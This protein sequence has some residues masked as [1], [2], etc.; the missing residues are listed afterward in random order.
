MGKAEQPGLAGVRA[1]L[2]RAHIQLDELDLQ[3]EA[4]GDREPYGTSDAQPN[5]DRRQWVWYL[6]FRPQMPLTWG[7]MLGEIVHDLRSALD[8][9]IFQLTLN[10]VH[11]EISGTGFPIS[12][13]PTSWDKRGGKR[14]A[15]NPLAYD[16]RCAMYQLRGVG[17]GVVEYIKRLQPYSTQDPKSS[18]LLA[19]HALW[20]QDKHRLIH[21]WGLELDQGRSEIRYEGPP[22]PHKVLFETGV[23]HDGDKAASITFDGPV[24][25]GHLS[26]RFATK[27]AFENPVDP[28]PAP[29]DSLMRLHDATAA[30]VYSLLARIG[31]QD[32]TLA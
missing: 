17:P 4:F 23:L 9:A 7:V 10:Y 5:A 29:G 14:Q 16:W 15:D 25:E 2:D 20:N 27:L 1:K 32:E 19:L 8:H 22:R 30:V 11:R 24:D 13:D 21:A 26:G 12:D 3:M 31:H 6:K 28:S 18:P